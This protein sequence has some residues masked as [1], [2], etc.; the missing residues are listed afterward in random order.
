MKTLA[1]FGA[2]GGVGRTTLTWHLGAMM[3]GLGRRVLLVDLDPQC[4][5][6]EAV[7][8]EPELDGLWSAQ[9]TDA[10][11]ARKTAFTQLQA[12]LDPTRAP[13]PQVLALRE[14]L[15]LLP[16]DPALHGL[17][18]ALETCWRDA[19]RGDTGALAQVAAVQRMI[20]AAADLCGAEIVLVDLAPA[21]SALNRAALIA[22]DQVLIPLAPDRY[23]PVELPLLGQALGAWRRAWAARR[24][25]A[26]SSPLPEGAMRPLGYVLVQAGMRL[27][28]PVADYGRWLRVIPGE[29]HRA[30]LG[31]PLAPP[32]PEADPWCLGATR[33]YP[34]LLPLARAARRPMFE[35]R[36]ADGA[37][38]A[39]MDAVL[40]CRADHEAL[41]RRI[42]E[43][44]NA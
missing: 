5:L 20:A 32:A 35:L 44:M 26:P 41:A 19:E 22:A 7:L 37:I 34:S 2:K 27:A 3:A 36:P 1:L 33:Q 6:S 18:E 30:I 25:D 16:G 38:G 9:G 13:V 31:D 12:A 24:G 11:D 17:M 8:A 43:R 21:L 29:Y 28:D 4:G 14:G 23:V 39:T 10:P 15:A 42:L 40:K